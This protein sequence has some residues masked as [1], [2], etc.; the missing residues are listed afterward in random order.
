MLYVD[1]M[2]CRLHIKG[3]SL[4]VQIHT[5]IYRSRETPLVLP[6]FSGKTT[7]LQAEE[8]TTCMSA[9]VSELLR[10]LPGSCCQVAPK[11]CGPCCGVQKCCAFPFR[12]TQQG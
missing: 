6:T 2:Q 7:V 4:D 9:S 1:M 10:Y 11:G 3:V 8:S 5:R 12:Q